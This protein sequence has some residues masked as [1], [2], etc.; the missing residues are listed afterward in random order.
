ME[1][2]QIKRS[3]REWDFQVSRSVGSL[4]AAW[5]IAIITS[6]GLLLSLFYIGAYLNKPKLIPYVVQLQGD[7]VQFTE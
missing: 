4:K 3:R 5:A 2:T 6:I 7:Q 1:T